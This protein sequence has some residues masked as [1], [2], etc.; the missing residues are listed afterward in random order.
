MSSI[1]PEESSPHAFPVVYL[2][3]DEFGEV[4][5]TVSQTCRFQ[6]VR[7]WPLCT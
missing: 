7:F 1:G 6:S 3:L 5:A 2:K 4:S